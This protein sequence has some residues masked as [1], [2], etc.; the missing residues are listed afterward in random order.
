MKSK[1]K[2][3]I[4][5]LLLFMLFLVPNLYAS[6]VSVATEQQLYGAALSPEDETIK[7]TDDIVVESSSYPQ[8]FSIQ[9]VD[10]TLDLNGHTLTVNNHTNIKFYNSNKKF[11]ITDSQGTGKIVCNTVFSDIL[12]EYE[13]NN[14]ILKDVT[15]DF[16]DRGGYIF[17]QGVVEHPIKVKAIVDGVIINTK[18]TP[19]GSSTDLLIKK[20]IVYPIQGGDSYIGFYNDSNENYL[21]DIVDSNSTIINCGNLVSKIRTQTWGRDIYFDASEDDVYLEIKPFTEMTNPLSV[22]FV[23]D[24]EPNQTLIVESGSKISD[25]Y[26]TNSLGLEANAWYTDSEL[27]NK[28][29]FSNPVT[30]NIILYPLLS[31]TYG[32]TCYDQTNDVIFAGGKATINDTTPNTNFGGRLRKGDTAMLYA[33]PNEGYRFVEWR[34]THKYGETFSTINP[35]EINTDMG[36]L[37][38]YAV[39]ERSDEPE[40]CTVTFRCLGG[41]PRDEWPE[42]VEINKGELCPVPDDLPQ[43]YDSLTLEGVYKDSACTDLFE[44]ELDTINEDITLYCKYVNESNVPTK[45]DMNNDNFVNSTDAAMVLDCF[46]NNNATE[47]DFARGDMDNNNM[48][49]ATDAAMILDIFKNS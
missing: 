6:T 7:L 29:E 15:F 17:Y 10:R 44:F 4:P 43:T 45:G 40:K 5:I 27:T 35:L 31:S 26:Y 42:P 18:T 33:F 21:S 12:N 3:S 23:L 47:E 46:K 37:S 30:T 32:I 25:P 41:L 28:F 24:N 16:Y 1:F 9:D 11:T 49:N 2:I 14:V 20:L 34:N 38:L 36:N 48:L 13:N 39:F 22:V 8:Y 19:F